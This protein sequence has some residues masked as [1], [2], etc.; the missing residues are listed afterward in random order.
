VVE[1]VRECFDKKFGLLGRDSGA[2]MSF[3][4]D[5]VSLVFALIDFNAVLTRVG[6][7]GTSTAEIEL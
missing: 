1:K 4:F 3:G 2:V 5:V 6:D 7:C